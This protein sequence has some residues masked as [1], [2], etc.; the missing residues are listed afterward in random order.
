M[1]TLATLKSTIADDLARPDLT[2]QIAAAITQAITFYKEERLF[3]TD[4]RT[5]N[6]DTIADQADYD[7]DDESTIPL[8]IQ[9]DALFLDDTDGTRYGPLTRI[10][11]TVMERLQDSSASTGRPSAWSWFNAGIWLHPIPDGVYTVRPL[12]QI[13]VAAP[14]GDNDAGN[15]WMTKGFELIRCRA[16]ALI[17][18]HT[19]KNAEQSMLMR[20][21]AREELDFLRRDSSK[22]G[23][24]LG[25]IRAT[26]F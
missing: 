23:A 7:V 10:D 1:S 26:S 3:W 20:E 9:I 24:P 12:G 16:K 22:R 19:V 6:F 5:E 18:T 2:A 21:A 8:F 17:F 25:Q 14:S 13:E 4:T 15:K 11:Q